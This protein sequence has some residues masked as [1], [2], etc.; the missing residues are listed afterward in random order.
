MSEWVG[1]VDIDL[2]SVD[3]DLISGF[4]PHKETVLSCIGIL[5]SNRMKISIEG[6]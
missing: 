2:D 3:C 5:G 6:N 1:K 4:P